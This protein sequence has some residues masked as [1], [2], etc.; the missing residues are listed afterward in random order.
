MATYGYHSGPRTVVDLPVA[1]TAAIAE[2]DMLKIDGVAGYV[3]PCGAGD[4]PIG[5]AA[6]K[7][8]A[9]TSDGDFIVPVYVSPSTV[10][11]YPQDAGSLS[12]A[13]MGGTM[14]V[15]G[16]Q[17]IDIDASTDNTIYCVG[18]D[19]VDSKLFVRID[20]NAGFTGV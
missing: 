18:V 19:L 9:P 10:F 7:C 14:D 6:A 5:V 16:A 12:A 11:S 17:S 3:T 8:D 1:N 20:F 13:L 2:G 15:G 4:L